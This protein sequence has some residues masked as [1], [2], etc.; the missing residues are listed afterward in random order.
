MAPDFR[1]TI[2]SSSPEEATPPLEEATMF[3][4][5][6][7]PALLEHNL[8]QPFLL[9]MPNSL[10]TW[11]TYIFY[12][13]IQGKYIDHITGPM[14]VLSFEKKNIDHIFSGQ[15]PRYLAIE[16]YIA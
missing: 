15:S 12:T 3:P 8:T 7:L 4:P 2:T 1:V 16:V 14:L 13:G 5:H 6:L 10:K 11:I 9:S